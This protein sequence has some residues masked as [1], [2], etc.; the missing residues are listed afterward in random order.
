[1]GFPFILLP[2]VSTLKLEADRK[3]SGYDC[4]HSLPQVT[5]ANTPI[6]RLINISDSCEHGPNRPAKTKTK[7]KT[8]GCSQDAF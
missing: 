8:N 3:K 2:I 7:E 6:P 5:A 4:S 1:M